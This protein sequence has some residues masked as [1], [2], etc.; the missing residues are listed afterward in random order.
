[1]PS[2]I[3]ENNA[4]FIHSKK[5]VQSEKKLKSE[6]NFDVTHWKTWR[7]LIPLFEQISFQNAVLILIWNLKTNRF[8]YAVDKRHVADYDTTLYLA[9]NGVHFLL[10]NMHPCFARSGI[11]MQQETLKYFISEPNEELHKTTINYEGKY[12]KNCGEYFHFLQQVVCMDYDHNGQAFLFL[13]YIQDISHLKKS[14]TVNFVIKTPKI[15]KW[16]SFNF[17]NN[18]LE[19]VIPLSNQE[20]KILNYLAK[21]KSSKEI[22]GELFISPLTVDTH[23]RHLLH[24]TNCIDTTGMITYLRLVGVL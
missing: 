10:S 9:D 11:I 20:K 16:Q 21:G 19:S 6:F 3:L 14:N 15:I 17:D 24:K 13:N 4:V 2:K 22:A 12:K 8:V 18:C 7:L 23:R 1:M 5:L